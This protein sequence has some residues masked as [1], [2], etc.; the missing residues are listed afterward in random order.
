MHT[1]KLTGLR[2]RPAWPPTEDYAKF[3][4]IAHLPAYAGT[5]LT[6]R[7]LLEGRINLRLRGLP[8]IVDLDEQPT[9]RAALPRMAL[10]DNS[11]VGVPANMAWTQ[12][13]LDD[14]FGYSSYGEA[15]NAWL[16]ATP[17]QAATRW[18]CVPQFM[19]R[20][21]DAAREE[22][23]RREARAVRQKQRALAAGQRC[24]GLCAVCGEHGLRGRR[25]RA[26]RRP[27]P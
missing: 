22:A 20:A 19:V 1:P 8:S 3:L 24:R 17:S 12:A 7:E 2:S 23:A 5:D 18:T 26:G 21:I 13:M 27:R 9:Q 6:A 11:M 14:K 4:L 16:A 10:D 25:R 15:L